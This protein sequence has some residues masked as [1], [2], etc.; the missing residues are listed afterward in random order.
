M[1]SPS[2]ISLAKRLT[3]ALPVGL[4]RAFFLSTGGESNEAA[5]RW[6]MT[7]FFLILV[8]AADRGRSSRLAKTYTGKYEVVGL[9]DSWHGMTAQAQGIQFKAGRQ[10][11]G[12]LFSKAAEAVTEICR[13]THAWP[14]HASSAECIP[15]DLPE[16][17]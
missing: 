11:H 10:G 13:A 1:I 4:D 9:G 12:K 15:L 7:N 17:R 3:S 5:I 14:I 6:T 8:F 2:V 16:Q